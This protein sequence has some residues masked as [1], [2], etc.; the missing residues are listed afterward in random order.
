MK[1]NNE[2]PVRSGDQDTGENQ[3]WKDLS[4]EV[5]P[6]DGG[7]EE[8]CDKDCPICG[9]TGFTPGWLM[10]PCPHSLRLLF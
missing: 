7:M 10:L 6:V 9:G 5:R 8:G 1:K 3:D 4:R 2:K